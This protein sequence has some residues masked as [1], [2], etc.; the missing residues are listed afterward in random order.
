MNQRIVAIA[1][2]HH[3]RPRRVRMQHRQLLQGIAGRRIHID[4]HYIRL[5]ALHGMQQCTDRGHVI[6]HL[7]AGARQWLAQFVDRLF[8]IVDQQNTH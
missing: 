6:E 1:R 3:H 8:G 4:H 7:V 5:L 2:E